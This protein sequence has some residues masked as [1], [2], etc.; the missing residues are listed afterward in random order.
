MFGTF[1]SPLNLCGT[2]FLHSG[3][4]QWHPEFT[5]QIS[6][7]MP[8]VFIRAN[9]AKTST[10]LSIFFPKADLLFLNV[11]P[12]EFQQNSAVVTKPQWE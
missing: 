9:H 11:Q 4:A 5:H 7:V 3:I 12:V 10:K 2:I 8:I 1:S 6:T